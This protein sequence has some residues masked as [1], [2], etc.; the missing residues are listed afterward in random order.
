MIVVFDMDDT[1]Y[2][3]AT[4]AQSGL[5]H[6]AHCIETDCG[7]PYAQ[8]LARLTARFT[9]GRNHIIDGTL[10]DLGIY[11]PTRAM[12]LVRRYRR[13]RPNIQRLP[14]VTPCFKRFKDWPKYL[15]TDGNRT[16]QAQKVKA[17]RLQ[18]VMRHCYL[19]GNYPKNYAKPS[20][21][22]FLQICAQEA[23]SPESVVYVADNP[24]K[25]FVGIR[26]LGFRTIR[27]MR[28]PYKEVQVRPEADA[29]IRIESLEVLSP[30]FLLET[31]GMP[32]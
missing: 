11:T 8:S 4:Y 16:A 7:I 20:P 13:H 23:V 10:Q 28:G 3:E 22:C 6:V 19:T 15:V 17:L 18:G 21:Y 32:R 5:N 29:E 27:V 31:L 2:D 25:D 26:P 12:D 14:D 24:H 9:Q 30:A 1:L